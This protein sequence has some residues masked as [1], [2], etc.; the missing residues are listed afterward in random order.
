MIALAVT[1][2]MGVDAQFKFGLDTGPGDHFVDSI[3]CEWPLALRLKDEISNWVVPAKLPQRPNF[4]PLQIVNGGI[5][6]LEAI[7]P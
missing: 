1:K 6:I 7:T 2:H 4:I 5:A 3:G